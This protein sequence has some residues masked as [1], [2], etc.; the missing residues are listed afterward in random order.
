MIASA[1]KS[2]FS[3]EVALTLEGTKP[4]KKGV[5]TLPGTTL[6]QDT[7]LKVL[8]DFYFYKYTSTADIAIG[9]ALTYATNT[10][11][12]Y[13][14]DGYFKDKDGTPLGILV[15]PA[16]ITIDQFGFDVDTKKQVYKG[17][18]GGTL[19]ATAI[20]KSLLKADVKLEV[21]VAGRCSYLPIITGKCVPIV[22]AV[23]SLDTSKI[24]INLC[25]GY[26]YIHAHLST[27]KLPS[28]LNKI[29]TTADALLYIAVPKTTAPGTNGMGCFYV[30]A[31]MDV[32]IPYILP[33]ASAGFGVGYNVSTSNTTIP[34]ASMTKLA[35]YVGS[36]TMNGMYAYAN[37][38]T[39]SSGAY[40][41]DVLG[42]VYADFKYDQYLK[43]GFSFYADVVTPTLNLSVNFKDHTSGKVHAG[44]LGLDVDLGGVFDCKFDASADFSPSGFDIKGS[45]AARAEI[46]GGLNS[47]VDPS[48]IGCNDYEV[49]YWGGFIPD[50]IGGKVCLGVSLFGEIKSGKSPSITASFSTD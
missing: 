4:G 16:K 7:K 26:A 27:S 2:G 50:G 23:F 49:D 33:N 48:T 37:K 42:I 21:L 13:T 24:D 11:K 29:N 47:P 14:S 31:D 39:T 46:Y 32:S 38:E 34:A 6:Q 45:G 3:A 22:G 36:G 12:K 44:L 20:D 30:E 15:G 28:P 35:S 8:V 10:N 25:D 5:T 41:F 9:A 19:T 40:G 1:E 18:I 17:F 43:Y